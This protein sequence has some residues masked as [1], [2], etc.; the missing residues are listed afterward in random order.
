MVICPRQKKQ[1]QQLT[2]NLS[3]KSTDI[4]QVEEHRLLGVLIDSN[5]TWRSHIES[6]CKK[7]S[8]NLYLLRRLEPLVDA[9]SLNS[10]FHAHCLA[11]INYASTVWCNA[12]AVHVDKLERVHKRGVKLLSRNMVPKTDRNMMYKQTGILPL[13]H[14][15]Q[16][17]LALLMF[18][19]ING[20]APEY[21]KDLL[22]QPRFSRGRFIYNLPLPR[23]DIFKS[24]FSFCGPKVWNS[25]PQ[26]CVA[27]NKTKNFKQALK[28]HF[29]PP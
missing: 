3:I 29:L 13:N 16:Y 11:H 25:L 23:I 21:L 5:L 20:T 8:R 19:I 1:R 6:L 15:F 10:F 17:N 22:Q 2:L 27:F 28:R 7:V 26:S 12:S 9:T 24:S 14:Q 4:A 18:K